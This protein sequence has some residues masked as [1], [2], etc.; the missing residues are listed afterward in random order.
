M[1]NVVPNGSVKIW[2]KREENIQLEGLKVA[3]MHFQGCFEEA[4][5][6]GSGHRDTYIGEIEETRVES[7]FL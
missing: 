2:V 7:C 1:W 3:T 5:E 4:M 6:E